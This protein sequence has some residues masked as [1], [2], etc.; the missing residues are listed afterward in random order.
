[1]LE[2]VDS[3]RFGI[4]SLL[5]VFCHLLAHELRNLLEIRR[6][7]GDFQNGK[8]AALVLHPVILAAGCEALPCARSRLTSISAQVLA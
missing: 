8:A 1:M 7:L 4:A 3:A 5:L 6:C 2:V